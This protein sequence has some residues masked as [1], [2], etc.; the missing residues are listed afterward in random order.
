MRNSLDDVSDIAVIGNAL[1][2]NRCLFIYLLRERDK[3]RMRHKANKWP[4]PLPCFCLEDTT[5]CS[6]RHLFIYLFYLFIHFLR[7]G[8]SFVISAADPF[9][10]RIFLFLK[11][12]SFQRIF[13]FFN[14]VHS[15]L[16]WHL[17]KKIYMHV[18]PLKT[19]LNIY[20]KINK[21]YGAWKKINKFYLKF[22]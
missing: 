5:N 20:F 10:K 17:E 14:K 11:S 2:W 22:F 19:F 16:K 4:R 21:F 12:H 13:F 3:E 15:C 9:K 1:L 8:K 6:M 7:R 18:G